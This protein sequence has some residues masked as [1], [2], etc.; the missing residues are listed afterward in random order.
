[1]AERLPPL[2]GLVLAG[3]R[4]LRFGSDKASARYAGESLLS[5]AVAAVGAVVADVRV[6]ARPEQMQ[7]DERRAF[8]LIADRL[9]DIG[10]AAGILAAHETEPESAWLVVACDMPRLDAATLAR[11]V[12]AR[13]PAREATA[14]CAPRDGRPEPLCAIYE[15]ATLARFRR[16]VEQGG[17]PS[18]RAWLAAADTRLVEPPDASALA[19]ANTPE[20]L[21]RLRS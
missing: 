4:S 17:N 7:D 6:A 5:R 9:H 2:R 10:P 21:E 8:R 14:F 13:D 11:L 3:G 20:E 16:Q 18:A 19:N 1:M 15:P 12:A